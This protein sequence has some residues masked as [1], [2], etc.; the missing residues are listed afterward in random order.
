MTC[1]IID[2]NPIAR[3]TLNHLASQVAGL[4]VIRECSSAI[5]AFN[6]LQADSVDLLFLDIEMPGMNGL[7]LTRNLGNNDVLIVFT[8]SKKEYAAEAFELNVVDYLVKP[9]SPG[10]FLQAV[11][12][13]REIL[14]S[15]K[16]EIRFT[17]DEFIFVRDSTVV[18]KLKVDDILYAEAMGDYV[19]FNTPQ[20]SYTIHCTMK[21][22]EERLPASKFIRVH[23]SYIVA[24]GKIDTLQEGGLVVGGQFLPVADAYRKVL[25]NRM[26]IF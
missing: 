4:N 15:K 2:D 19:K 5:E 22:A 7:E 11:N 12:K 26:N 24:L 9:V 20:K 10:R 3:T 16:E 1:L 8:T 21:L 14:D 17:N 6:H 13:A 25:N 18:R 23:R